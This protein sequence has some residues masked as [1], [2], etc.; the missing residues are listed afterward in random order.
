MR[1]L[2]LYFWLCAIL[3]FF[4]CTKSQTQVESLT[5]EDMA[6]IIGLR[7]NLVSA[8]K[9]GDAKTY[10]HL[11]SDNVKLMHPKAPIVTGRKELI[12]H[13]AA[14]FKAVKVT[15][16]ILTPVD[17]YGVGNLAYEVGTQSVQIDP[18]VEG[19]NASRK[20]LHVMR[21]SDDGAWQ[22]VALMSSD[23]E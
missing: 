20:Y 8:I 1:K 17:V 3:I 6:A 2:L 9:A 11:C 5:Q 7:H 18:P 15:S 10:G 4:G 13:N 16:L 12:K 22:F 14:M 19:F 21:K 23:S